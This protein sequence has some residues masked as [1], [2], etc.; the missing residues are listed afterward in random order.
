MAEPLTLSVTLR[1]GSPL[2]IG[3][4]ALLPIERSVRRSWGGPAG[5][6]FSITLEPYALVIRDAA[7]IRAFG[8]D[9]GELA[10]D[11][12]RLGVAGLDEALASI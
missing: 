12:L 4:V 8:V 1:A 7:G 3:A 9:A 6:G 10:L 5:A 2:V 11:P